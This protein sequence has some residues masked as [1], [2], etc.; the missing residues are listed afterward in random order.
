MD[1]LTL[2]IPEALKSK[3]SRY[4]K[5]KG[6]SRSEIVRKALSDFFSE[7]DIRLNGAFIDFS[8]DLAGTIEGPSDLSANKKYLDGYGK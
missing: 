8:E 3:L 7:D 1:T 5:Q 4:A 6:I 2:K